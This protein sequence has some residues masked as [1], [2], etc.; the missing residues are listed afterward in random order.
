MEQTYEAR[1]VLREGMH[2]E[3]ETR[4]TETIAVHMDSDEEFGGRGKGARPLDLMLISLAGCTGMDVISIL[5]KKQQQIYSLAI[6][7]RSE[8]AT[9]YPKV[10]THVW[11]TYIVTGRS[12]DPAAVVRSID[13]SINKYCPAA[14]MFKQAGVPIEADYK[15][16][17]AV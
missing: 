8:R 5:R 3:G 2:F 16:V 17:E 7:V 11:I 13:L 10:F 4:H 14:G 15:I 9:D 1:V 12:V 6:L